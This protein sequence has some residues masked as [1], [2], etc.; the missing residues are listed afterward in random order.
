MKY[1]CVYVCEYVYM[2]VNHDHHKH[3][4]LKNKYNLS[5]YMGLAVLCS[6]FNVTA[7]TS[8]CPSLKSLFQQLQVQQREKKVTQQHQTMFDS[9]CFY[10]LSVQIK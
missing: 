2:C 4:N 9:F 7:K 5:Q 6:V 3:V 1:M 8:L 10:P